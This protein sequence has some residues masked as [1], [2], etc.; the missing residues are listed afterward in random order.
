MALWKVTQYSPR[1]SKGPMKIQMKMKKR[2]LLF[3]LFMTFTEPGSR[4]EFDEAVLKPAS[5]RK[6]PGFP[7]C[8]LSHMFKRDN[9]LLQG[10]W[11]QRCIVIGASIIWFLRKK[12]KTCVNFRIWN[13]P[14]L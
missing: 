4:N 9:T 3:P 10:T 1:L 8:L 6:L 13:R 12:N 7:F 5:E 2:G 14:M 11:K